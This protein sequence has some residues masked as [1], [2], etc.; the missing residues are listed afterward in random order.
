M[1]SLTNSINIVKSFVIID[2]ETKVYH[3]EVPHCVS[4]DSKSI[5]DM[6]QSIQGTDKNGKSIKLLRWILCGHNDVDIPVVDISCESKLIQGTFF[7]KKLY[8]FVLIRQ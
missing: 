8:I 6:L 4:K 1:V 7:F 3:W 2:G 5:V